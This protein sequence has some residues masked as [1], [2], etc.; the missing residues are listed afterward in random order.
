MSAMTDEAKR[1]QIEKMYQHS[2]EHFPEVPEISAEALKQLQNDSS[3]VVVDVRTSAEQAVSMI[4]GAITADDFEA[5]AGDYKGSTIVTYCTIGHRS[6]L[7]A[8]PLLAR[9]FNV[10]NLKG[11]ILSWT[12][13]GGGLTTPDGPTRA[14]HVCKRKFALHADGYDPV[15]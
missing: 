9:G 6:G 4:P 2:R 10:F 1:E 14:V 5:N 8:Q 13:S 12:H 11:A 15:W 3:V 7:Y